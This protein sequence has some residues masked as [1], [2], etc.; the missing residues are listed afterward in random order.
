M[1]LGFRRLLHEDSIASERRK[2]S[3]EY[4]P[5][6]RSSM[7][8]LALLEELPSCL[9]FKQ[10]MWLLNRRLDSLHP[11]KTGSSGG[12]GNVPAALTLTTGPHE[13]AEAL[14]RRIEG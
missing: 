10:N 4:R 8:V 3:G 2:K 7:L 9:I 14:T 5:I 13:W 12:T 1:G 11:A 6:S